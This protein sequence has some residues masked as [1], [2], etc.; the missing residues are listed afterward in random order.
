MQIQDRQ[1]ID[2]S[3]VQDSLSA[4]RIATVKRTTKETDIAVTLNLDGQ[5][6]SNIKANR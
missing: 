4:N 1:A 3:S 5:G 2:H 6:N